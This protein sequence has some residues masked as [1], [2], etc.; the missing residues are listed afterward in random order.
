[1]RLKRLSNAT[2]DRKVVAFAH[3]SRLWG[4][5][6]VFRDSTPTADVSDGAP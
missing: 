1:M 6:D 3:T 5:A 2:Y 4:G